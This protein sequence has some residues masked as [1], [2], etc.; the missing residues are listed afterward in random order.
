MW[1]YIPFTFKNSLRNKR[2]TILTIASISISLFLL[3]MLVAVYHAFYYREAPPEQALRLV[4]RHR[5]SLT[6]PLPEYYEQRIRQIQGV[7]EV[8][9]Y[10]WFGG[11]YID[12]RPEHFFARFSTDPEKIFSVHNEFK[13]SPEQLKAFQSERTAVAMGKSLAEKLNL[14]LGQKITI[15]GDIY[16][17]DVELTLRALF[18]SDVKGADYVMYFHRKYLEESL[19]TTRRGTVGTFAVLADSPESVPRIAREIDEM[20]HNSDSQTK[21]ESEQAFQLSFLSMLG[22]VKLFLLSICGAVVFTILLVSGNTMAMSVRE[23]IKE[24][25]VLKTLGFTTSQ[26]LLMVI[27]ESV[28][29]ALAGGMLGCGLASG[30]CFLLSGAQLPFMPLGLP[31]PPVVLTISLAVAFAIGF[32]SSVVPALNAS[33][34]PITEALRHI[35]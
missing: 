10:S 16:P 3:G 15:K 32:F 2:R 24:I 11:V 17:V 23:R 1:K 33:R 34:V 20:F 35:G 29:I 27:A 8:C 5:V 28:I 13:I 6:F 21:T 31:M 9:P 12:R 14:K 25:G 18:E 26:V 7:R 22:N 4:V 30:V 19:P